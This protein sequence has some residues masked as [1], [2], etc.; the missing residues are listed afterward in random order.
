VLW[1]LPPDP[2]AAGLSWTPNTWVVRGNLPSDT[3]GV[4]KMD[5]QTAIFS[6]ENDGEW[7]LTSKFEGTLFRRKWLVFVTFCDILW[8]FLPG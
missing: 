7:W 3:Q 6:R 8:L 1:A 4:V 2:L 5:P